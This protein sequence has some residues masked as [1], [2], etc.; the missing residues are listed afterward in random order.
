MQSSTDTERRETR[1]GKDEFDALLE[2]V[3]ETKVVLAPTAAETAAIALL[4]Q[5]AVSIALRSHCETLGISNIR[6]KGTHRA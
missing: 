3:I 5:D 1:T 2:K 6:V 4:A